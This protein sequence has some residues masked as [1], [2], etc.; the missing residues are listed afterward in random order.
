MKPNWPVRKANLIGTTEWLACTLEKSLLAWL[1]NTEINV[2]TSNILTQKLMIAHKY[3]RRICVLWTFIESS[4]D[5]KT[6][7]LWWKPS[8]PFY[9]FLSRSQPPDISV[10]SAG[11]V[12]FYFGASD[13]AHMPMGH[14]V[15]KA[16]PDASRLAIWPG[17]TRRGTRG[18]VVLNITKPPRFQ[19]RIYA[20][21]T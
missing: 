10:N 19:H 12:W 2:T 20:H 13:C 16:H 9:S 15:L 6:L 5:P 8:P 21:D 11:P 4:Q 18:R 3:G 1:L 7:Q 14:V 17:V